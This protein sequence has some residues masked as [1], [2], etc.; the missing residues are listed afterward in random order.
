MLAY[1]DVCVAITV[2]PLPHIP[3]SPHLSSRIL[4]HAHVCPRML[5]YTFL[6]HHALSVNQGVFPGFLG[7]RRG[8]GQKEGE[9]DA[10]RR[11][12]SV[13]VLTATSASVGY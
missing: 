4:T 2:L 10:V 11:D 9:G 12:G 5:T 6:T 3:T 7:K 8:G 1:A 13:H